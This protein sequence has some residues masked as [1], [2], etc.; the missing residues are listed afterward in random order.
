LETERQKSRYGG[1]KNNIHHLAFK[2]TTGVPLF[3]IFP[4]G[5]KIE[6]S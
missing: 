5:T 6:A 1:G 4:M 3:E 2:F